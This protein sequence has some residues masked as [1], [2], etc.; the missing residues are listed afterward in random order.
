MRRILDLESCESFGIKRFHLLNMI[1]RVI[2]NPVLCMLTV[3]CINNNVNAASD[4]IIQDCDDCPSLVIIPAGEIDIRVPPGVIGRAHNAG[5]YTRVSFARAYAIGVFEVTNEQWHACIIA[6]GCDQLDYD[7]TLNQQ[8]PATK[9]SWQQARKYNQWLSKK[10]GYNYRLPSNTE[11]EYAARAGRG[12][13]RYFN[14]L[15]QD[16][17]DLGNVYDQT[18]ERILAYNLDTLPCDDGKVSLAPVGEFEPNAFGLYDT[19]GN[20][21]EWT[22][23]CASPGNFDASGLPTNGDPWFVGDCSLRGYR[24]SSWLTNESTYLIES[25]RFRDLTS[26]EEDLGFRVV[27]DIP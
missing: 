7:T 16:I 12:M 11:W 24:G 25:D 26:S 20:A 4:Q 6:G 18:A 21:F 19:I 8:Y 3:A 5:W 1:K 22:E 17:C 10:T 27:R 9:I 2:S 14:V 15:P 23:D 13:N